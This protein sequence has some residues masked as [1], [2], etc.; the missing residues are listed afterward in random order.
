MHPLA[1]LTWRILPLTGAVEQGLAVHPGG[2]AERARW[3]LER[4]VGGLTRRGEAV[5]VSDLTLCQSDALLAGIYRQLY[6]EAIP[7]Q[8]QCGGCGTGF[9][10]GFRLRDV[11]AALWQEAAEFEGAHE[12]RLTAPSGRVFRLPRVA[13]LA[14]L[15]DAGRDEWLRGFLVDGPF[16]P[17]ALQDEIDRAGP[18][19]SRDIDAACPEC[20]KANVVRFDMA[21]FL[22]DTLAGEG[23]FLWREVHLLASRYGWALND[24][25]ALPRETR[26]Q[27]A[28]FIVAEAPRTRLAS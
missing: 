6:G 3:L 19:L 14:A 15:T 25:L 1:D 4:L 22:G 17:A 23:P 11:E 9:E 27:L 7:A 18:L 10:I 12:G 2:V 26:R 16:D 21:A 28:G 20:G 13:D 24:I 8:A 5:D